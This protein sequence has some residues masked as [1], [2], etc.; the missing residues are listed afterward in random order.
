MVWLG[1][2]D[3]PMAV[4]EWKGGVDGTTQLAVSVSLP[5]ALG[6]RPSASNCESVA[7]GVGALA[8]IVYQCELSNR[9]ML[10]TCHDLSPGLHSFC[11]C[12]TSGVPTNKL[13]PYHGIFIGDIA[14]GYFAIFVSKHAAV[15]VSWFPLC[16]RGVQLTHFTRRA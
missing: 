12:F 2:V 16:K 11:C 6:G 4:S 1:G 7:P 15:G 3:G 8:I 10:H 5:L 14:C 13:S 9:K